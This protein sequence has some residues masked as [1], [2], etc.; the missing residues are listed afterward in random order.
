MKRVSLDQEL[1]ELNV[2]NRQAQQEVSQNQK[3]LER[4]KRTLKK[5]QIN[6]EG[7][8]ETLPPLAESKDELDKTAKGQDEE[9]KR[10]KKLLDDIQAEVDL[11]IGAYLKQES[12]EK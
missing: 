3:Q 7:V 2:D 12:L 6:K 4:L 11:F 10:Q 9:I 1:D 8:L 5:T